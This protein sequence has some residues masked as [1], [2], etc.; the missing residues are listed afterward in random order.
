M[1][2]MAR[3]IHESGKALQRHWHHVGQVL[4]LPDCNLVIPGSDDPLVALLDR[5]AGIDC[6]IATR[7]KGVSGIAT[8]VQ[9][10]GIFPTIT[11]RNRSS[12]SE[13]SRACQTY[14]DG[15]ARLRPDWSVHLYEDKTT[16]RL[17]GF[18]A[19]HVDD[20][21]RYYINGGLVTYKENHDDGTP[22]CGFGIR[23]LRAAGI[24]VR[25]WWRQGIDPWT[26]SLW[27]AS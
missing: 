21:A 22:F 26:D 15:D 1:T 16:R 27:D 6:L 11:W 8:R 13:L 17:L 10:R 14:L 7:G 23:N 2:D 19:A 24:E 4:G 9:W 18:A 12:K 20:L 3:L 5:L 25:D